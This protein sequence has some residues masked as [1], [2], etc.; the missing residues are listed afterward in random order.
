MAA[1]RL[2]L[3]VVNSG[4][5][6]GRAGLLSAVASLWGAEALEALGPPAPQYAGSSWTKDGTCVLCIGRRILNHWTT[7]EAPTCVLSM[8][9][10]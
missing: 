10:M 7:Q 3:D 2:P 8:G 5:S 9:E 1:R 4:Y 6:S